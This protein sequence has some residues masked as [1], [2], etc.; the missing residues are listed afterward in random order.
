MRQY[1]RG[2]PIKLKWSGDQLTGQLL[3]EN[4]LWAYVEWSEKRQEWCIEDSL[5]RCLKHA[6]DLR[7][8]ADSKHGV[9]ELAQQMIRDGRLPTPLEALDTGMPNASAGDGA[10]PRSAGAKSSNRLRER[11]K[12]AQPRAMECRLARG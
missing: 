10:R 7:G 5:G 2:G 6:G 3:I 9:I 4:V 1:D 8:T 12:R 11:N